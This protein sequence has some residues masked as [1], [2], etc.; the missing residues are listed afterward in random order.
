[1]KDHEGRSGP[2]VQRERSVRRSVT[3]KSRSERSMPVGGTT[4]E[5]TAPRPHAPVRQA[6]HA[7]RPST[8]GTN[9]AVSGRMTARLVKLVAARGLDPDAICSKAGVSLD[10]VSN[11]LA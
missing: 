6:A 5:L 10:E 3:S 2:R 8:G 11:P 7:T 9:G 4:H 1:M